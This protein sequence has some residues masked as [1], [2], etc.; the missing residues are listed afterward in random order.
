MQLATSQNIAAIP[1]SWPGVTLRRGSSGVSVRILQRQLSRIAKDYPAFGKPEA[2]GI[3]DEATET[4]VKRFQ[5]QFSLTADGL[6]GKAT[7]YKVS[8]VCWSKR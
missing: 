1:G 3:F 5:K 4:S 6:V 2:S 8:Y 7:W